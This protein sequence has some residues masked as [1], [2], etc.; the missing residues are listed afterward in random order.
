MSKV[1]SLQVM[2]L[3]KAGCGSNVMQNSIYEGNRKNQKAT[4]YFYFCHV[5]LFLFFVV[6]EGSFSFQFSFGQEK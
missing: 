6:V 2:M 5:V 1:E 3:S 4:E